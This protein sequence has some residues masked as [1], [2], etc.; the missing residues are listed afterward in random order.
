MVGD[1]PKG[2]PFRSP[3]R[4]QRLD[5]KDKITRRYSFIDSMHIEI[6]YNKE[7]IKD[8]ILGALATGFFT[9]FSPI[10]PGLAAN[11]AGVL[12]WWIIRPSAVALQLLAVLMIH[13]AGWFAARAAQD[14]WGEEDRR[15]VIGDLAGMWL[16][17]A[18][19]PKNPWL[20]LVG[21]VLYRLVD[22]VKFYPALYAS[23]FGP[24]WGIMAEKAVAGAYSASLLTVAEL[25]F[26]SFPTYGMLMA[27]ASVYLTVI[28]AASASHI[29]GSVRGGLVILSISFGCFLFWLLAP[30]NPWTQ[31]AILFA[32]AA[33]LMA[34]LRILAGNP[35]VLAIVDYALLV[36]GCWLSL[37]FLPKAGLII[38]S[39]ALLMALFRHLRPYPTN[40][41][42]NWGLEASM[43]LPNAIAAIYSGVLLQVGLMLFGE[44]DRGFI[45]YAVTGILRLFNI[46]G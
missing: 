2:Y 38:I 33:A 23:R 3:L 9:G 36:W 20:W 27:R 30:A 26:S 44:S 42:P 21:L 5:R 18:T 11:L 7:K 34:L 29:Y 19:F 13:V 16:A 12:L 43:I 40:Y 39:G 24:G 4:K 6:R 14:W 22:A 31:L 35:W 32:T 15:I 17:L 46:R 10:L 8:N 37:W 1:G 41:L 25:L 28:A 45:K